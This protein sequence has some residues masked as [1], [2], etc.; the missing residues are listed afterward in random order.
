MF[1]FEGLIDLQ[2]KKHSS[3]GT[4][5]YFDFSTQLPL[6]TC[7]LWNPPLSSFLALQPK[8]Q[9]A[10]LDTGLMTQSSPDSYWGYG[11]ACLMENMLQK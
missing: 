11:V 6:L 9:L 3:N 5:L 4:V 1:Y 2:R 8:S 7:S 10:L